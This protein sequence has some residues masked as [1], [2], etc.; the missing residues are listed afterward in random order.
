MCLKA[1]VWVCK[2]CRIF[3]P[4]SYDFLCSV[5]VTSPL[6]AYTRPIQPHMYTYKSHSTLSPLPALHQCQKW[7]ISQRLSYISYDTTHVESN[8]WRVILSPTA[9]SLYLR[10]WV[11]LL[12]Q[13]VK[14]GS[15]G[16]FLGSQE[17]TPHTWFWALKKRHL[18][19]YR[20]RFEMYYILSLHSNITLY[21]H[22]RRLK[23][24][25]AVWHRN[26]KVH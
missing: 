21:K 11:N 15:H 12:P 8:Y 13:W 2:R 5:H 22:H 18:F 23:Y 19:H 4:L 14:S 17:Y 26:T 1:I 16:V 10:P 25:K 24:N 6:Q 3:L 7:N 9:C 20:Y